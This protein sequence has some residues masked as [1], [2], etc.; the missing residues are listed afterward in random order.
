MNRAEI[1]DDGLISVKCDVHNWMSAFIVVKA[2]PFWAV[3]AEDGTYRIENVPVGRYKLSVW[4]EELGMIE[5][6]ITVTAGKE[7]T[8][9]FDIGS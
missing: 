1:K 2:H 3:S 9:D 5:R 4:H 7:T 8:M 6:D